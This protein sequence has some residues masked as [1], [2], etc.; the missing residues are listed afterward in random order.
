MRPEGKL[1][2][3]KIG[4]HQFIDRKCKYMNR[5]YVKDRVSVITPIYNAEKYVK[6]TL[7]SIFAQTYK[8]IEIVLVDDCSKDDSA[9]IIAHIKEQHPEIVYFRQPKNMGAGAARNKALELA[10]GQY[11]AFLDS[12]DLWLPDKTARQVALMKEKNSPF[13]Y[14]AIEM[15]DESGKTIKKKRNIKE[16]CDYKYLLHNTIIATSSVIIDRRVLGD[17]RMPLR[18]GGQDYATWL[19]LLRGGAVACGINEVLVR[20]RVGSNSLSSNKFK[21][22]KQVWEIQTQDEHINPI[23]AMFHVGCFTINALKK[24]LI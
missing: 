23:L 13:S 11:V 10:T 3:I 4:L 21:S 1:S 6:K 24:Y 20:Y 17:F 5:E 15:M 18:R 2:F 14:A 7:S 8:N 16:T 12:D 19:M 22:V 9:Q